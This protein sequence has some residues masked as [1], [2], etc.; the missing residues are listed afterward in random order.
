M[1]VE[2][3]KIAGMQEGCPAGWRLP[4]NRS[5]ARTGGAHEDA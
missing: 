1:D 5:R 2:D 3:H 4:D